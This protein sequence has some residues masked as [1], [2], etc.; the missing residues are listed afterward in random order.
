MSDSLLARQ[1]TLLEN[2]ERILSQLKKYPNVVGVGVGLK[3]TN[4]EITSTLCYRVYVSRKKTIVELRE[5]ER[6][7]NIIEGFITDILPYGVIEETIDKTVYRPLKGGIQIKN[8]SYAVDSDKGGAGTLGCLVKLKDDEDSIVGLTCAHVVLLNSESTDA[9]SSA[10][11]QP[12]K[13]VCCCCCVKNI[14]GSVLQADKDF[15]CA[16]IE[17]HDDIQEEIKSKGA[18]N[19]I[20]EIGLIA[21]K[22]VPEVGAIVKKRGARTGVTRGKVVDVAFDIGQI[23]IA[24][25]SPYDKFADFGDSGAVVLDEHNRVIGLL[26]GTKRNRFKSDDPSIPDEDPRSEHNR[27]NRIKHRSQGV[28]IPIDTVEDKLGIKIP[29]SPLQVTPTIS[30][31]PDDTKTY[32]VPSILPVSSFQHFVTAKGDGDI[33]LKVTF[34]QPI[35]NDRIRWF[36]L[37]DILTPVP[38]DNSVIKISRNVEDGVKFEVG[39]KVD[40]YGVGKSALVWIVWSQGSIADLGIDAL[41]IVVGSTAIKATTTVRAEFQI[42]PKSIFPNDS[43]TDDVPD[44]RG[45]NTTPPPNVSDTDSNEVFN[46]GVDLSGGALFKWDASVSLR[47][48]IKNPKFVDISGIGGNFDK[49]ALEYPSSPLVGNYD[50]ETTPGA[51]P[52]SETI[53][54]ENGKVGKTIQIVHELPHSAGPLF[55]PLDNIK[56]EFRIDYRFFARVEL[57]GTWYLISDIDKMLG[58]TRL[59]YIRKDENAVGEL[60]NNDDHHELVWYGSTK[61]NGYGADMSIENAG[62]DG[63]N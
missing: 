31:H 4:D 22:A 49:T 55:P 50:T 5:H 51:N 58:K 48:N 21:G 15:D 33:I 37:A 12:Q 45:A 16:T 44:L 28:V 19:D 13:H 60:N 1:N 53:P 57:G 2:R 40:G 18:V 54:T 39:V 20:H 42:S 11:G 34:D 32:S 41:Q 62:N 35:E 52:Y 63:F 26:K 61:H 27:A 10:I 30:V 7:P 6:I 8:E 9:D 25:V 17:L 47:Y 43:S 38:G 3:E 56:I 29:F 59:Y 24:P 46:K 14:V 36:S 23:L